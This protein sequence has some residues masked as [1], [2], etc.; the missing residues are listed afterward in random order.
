LLAI[1]CS[2]IDLGYATPLGA[3]ATANPIFSLSTNG[4]KWT[5]TTVKGLETRAWVMQPNGDPANNILKTGVA[6]YMAFR[7]HFNNS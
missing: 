1:D 4:N 7:Y 3:G 6:R 2:I 5:S